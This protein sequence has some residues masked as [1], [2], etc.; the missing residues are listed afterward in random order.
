MEEIQAYLTKFC[1]KLKKH[2][3]SFDED[4]TRTHHGCNNHKNVIE[5][6]HNKNKNSNKN[7]T[8]NNERRHHL[9]SWGVVLRFFLGRKSSSPRQHA[10]T[11]RHGNNSVAIML[12][13]MQIISSFNFVQSQ[14]TCTGK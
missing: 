3:N 14:H 2:N 6:N 8:T 12:I 1:C 4:P 11:Y 9:G 13:V 10:V 5:N 7:N